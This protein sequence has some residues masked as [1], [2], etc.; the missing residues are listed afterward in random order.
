MS[1]FEITQKF[2]NHQPLQARE[3]RELSAERAQEHI[4]G[5]TD[6]YDRLQADD[7][8]QGVDTWPGRGQVK[9]TEKGQTSVMSYTGDTQNGQA[10]L[11]HEV[12]DS[13]YVLETIS[14]ETFFEGDTISQLQI[15]KNFRG[16]AISV[17]HL[18]RKDPDSSFELIL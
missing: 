4:D 3:K 2:R 18:D 9:K 5:I 13:H 14:H 17:F 11:V 15:H 12:R 6:L 7:E 10:S 16:T 8:V 1:N